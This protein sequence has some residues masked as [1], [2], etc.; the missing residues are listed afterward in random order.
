MRFSELG[1]TGIK[2][3]RICLGTMTYGE[4]NTQNE[5]FQQLDYALHRGINFIDTAELYAI[6]PKRETQGSTETIIGNWLSSLGNRDKVV[7]A[8]KISGR[9]DG[10]TWVRGGP[11]HTKAHIDQAIEDSL[12]RLQTDYIDLY[13]LHWPDRRYEGF[14]FHQFKDYDAD[15]EAFEDILQSLQAHI[16]KGN[17]RHF[18]VS[19]ESSW[20]V[21]RFIAESDKRGLARPVSIQNVYNLVS[22]AFEHGL[23]EVALREDVG[24]LAYS[25]LAQGYLTGKYRDGAR[26]YGSR[27]TLFG[28]LGRYEGP[29][30][31]EAIDAYVELAEALGVLPEAMALK[32]VDTR[33]FVTS[34]II[35]AT[36][37]EQLKIN[38]DSFDLPWTDEL[39]SKVHTQHLQRPNPCP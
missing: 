24:L 36:T 11:R 32:F 3:S 19:N 1:R 21:M 6:P 35:G 38:I 30:G 13:Q 4:Q 8:T 16:D 7:L 29:G 23:A 34:T 27:K 12:R 33:P 37:M 20:G 26:P 9:S 15:Y 10:M 14:G 17:I 25:P 31:V 22:R 28:R 2:V 39:E 5:A 18:G